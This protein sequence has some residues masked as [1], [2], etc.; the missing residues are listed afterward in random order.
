MF[1]RNVGLS[2]NCAAFQCRRL[3]PSYSLLWKP[4]IRNVEMISNYKQR[5][6]MML[7]RREFGRIRS[8]TVNKGLSPAFDKRRFE[9]TLRRAFNRNEIR[10]GYILCAGEAYYLYTNPIVEYCST[11]HVCSVDNP[12]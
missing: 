2:P 4:H 10:T 5:R 6:M 3:Y 8:W 11:N 7:S 12:S 9:E 1:I